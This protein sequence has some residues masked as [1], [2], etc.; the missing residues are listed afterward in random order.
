MFFVYVLRS[1]KDKKRYIG[2]TENLSRRIAEHNSGLV[3]STRQR[4]PLELLYYEEFNNKEDALK[5]E[6]FYKSGA[7]RALLKEMKL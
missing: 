5:K 1:A 7:G 2:V 6:S 3:K 4:R